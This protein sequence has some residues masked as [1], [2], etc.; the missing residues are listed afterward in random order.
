M[1]LTI[2]RYM[3]DAGYFTGH[4]GKYIQWWPQS[5]VAPHWDRWTYFKGGYYDYWVKR[6]TR[7]QPLR[8]R[9]TRRS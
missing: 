2:Q 4:S 1:D 8:R 5:T 3:H 9:S 6:T 7:R